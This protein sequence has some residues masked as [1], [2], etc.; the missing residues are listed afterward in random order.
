MNASR[1]RQR[2]YGS[3]LSFSAA[4]GVSIPNTPLS[5][6]SGPAVKNSVLPGPDAPPFPNASPHNP[7][8]YE[9]RP[10]LVPHVPMN[11]PVTAL[12]A[13]IVPSPKLPIKHGVAE[14][15][16]VRRRERHAPRRV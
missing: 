12:K 11:S 3:S 10:V 6:S 8:I 4:T 15:A 7:S 2:D 16:E 9:L 1:C 14:L 13:A 5:S